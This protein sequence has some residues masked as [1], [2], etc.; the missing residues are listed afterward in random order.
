MLYK[1]SKLIVIGW[2]LLGVFIGIGIKTINDAWIENREGGS[3]EKLPRRNFIVIIENDKQEDFFG[4]LKEF[5]EQQGFAL[6][7]APTTPDGGNF[8]VEMWREDIKIFGANPFSQGEF[9]IGFYDTDSGSPFPISDLT[10]NDL[11]TKFKSLL[12]EIPNVTII[13]E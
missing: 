9:R 1:H 6:R 11:V 2:L 10:L 12:S 13:E 3:Y 7:I 5:S 4:Q 8:S